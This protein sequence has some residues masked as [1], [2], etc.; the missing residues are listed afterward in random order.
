MRPVWEYLIIEE[1]NPTALQRRLVEAGL[2]G[3]EAVGFASAGE[4][5]LV[6]VMKRSS[7]ATSQ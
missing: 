5:R 4:A 3:W 2:E 6:V 1:P 7:A